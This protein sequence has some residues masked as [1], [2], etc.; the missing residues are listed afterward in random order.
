MRRSAW[1]F[2]LDY[3]GDVG[4]VVDY[5]DKLFPRLFNIFET[6]DVDTPG[7]RPVSADV[8]PYSIIQR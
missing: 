7:Y 3:R 5:V 1:I 2:L 6:A 8:I 4:D